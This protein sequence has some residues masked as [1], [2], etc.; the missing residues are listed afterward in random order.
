MGKASVPIAVIGMGC[1]L[2]GDAVD[3]EK[4]F[5]MCVEARDGWSTLPKDRLN[6][7]GWY[8][9][10]QGRHGAVSFQMSSPFEQVILILAD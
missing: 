9:P 4:L 6:S 5:D 3:P 2:S 8:H 1:R 7:D 10:H